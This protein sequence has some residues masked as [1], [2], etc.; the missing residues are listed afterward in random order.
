MV[1]R[2]SFINKLRELGYYYK[3][4]QKRTELW[5]KTGGTHRMFIPLNNMLLDETVAS[6]LAQAGCGSDEIQKFL[7]AAKC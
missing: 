5:R 4:K 6:L 3:S 1:P 2:Q 7:V